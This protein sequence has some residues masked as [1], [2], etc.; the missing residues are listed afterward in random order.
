MVVARHGK[1]G[2]FLLNHEIGKTALLGE[3]IAEAEA[4]VVETEAD[5]HQVARAL[6]LHTHEELVVVV[7]DGRLFAPHGV[8]GLVEGVGQHLFHDEASV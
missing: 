1:L 7:A 8:P 5:V 2:E 6:L 3:L 4:I